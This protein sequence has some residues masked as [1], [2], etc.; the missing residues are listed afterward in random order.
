MSCFP[1]KGKSPRDLRAVF[2]GNL[3]FLGSFIIPCQRRKQQS[4]DGSVFAD[5]MS[6]GTKGKIIQER[7]HARLKQRERSPWQFCC[8]GVIRAGGFLARK[9]GIA[10]RRISA[11]LPAFR[12]QRPSGERN[13]KNTSRPAWR[14]MVR[15]C[16]KMQFG[17]HST[18]DP[19]PCDRP[20]MFFSFI[21]PV[22]TAAKT[23]TLFRTFMLART[24]ASS[25][26]STSAILD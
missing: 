14:A 7:Q 9:R 20:I 21:L 26:K 15:P 22:W 23:W 8:N 3:P 17:L 2:H 11:A 16:R 18:G 5:R 12:C 4:S 24:I 10:R 13:R 6:P 1:D 25:A 19:Y